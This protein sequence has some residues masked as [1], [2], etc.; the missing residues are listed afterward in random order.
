MVSEQKRIKLL[1]P[2]IG[3]TDI[4]IGRTMYRYMH[5][6]LKSHSVLMKQLQTRNQPV[7]HYTRRWV[8]KFFSH[9]ISS[10]LD[11]SMNLLWP[12]PCNLFHEEMKKKGSLAFVLGREVEKFD[13]TQLN[14]M[15][16][17]LS[18]YMPYYQAIEIIDPPLSD[19]DLKRALVG[20]SGEALKE[21]CDRSMIN[22][23][24]LVQNILQLR[25]D[26]IVNTDNQKRTITSNLLLFYHTS[27]KEE[28]TGNRLSVLYEFARVVFQFH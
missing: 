15:T 2:D 27:V 26:R 3:L 20:E 6:F 19:E 23:H 9:T 24:D 18:P 22:C 11:V 7:Q 25:A 1:C 13:E 4:N 10:F 28:V 16:E 14:C 5:A 21:I 8:T 12:P 17:Q